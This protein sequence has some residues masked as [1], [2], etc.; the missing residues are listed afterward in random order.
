MEDDIN[1][2]GDEG[3]PTQ[4][5]PGV[6]GLHVNTANDSDELSDTESAHLETQSRLRRLSEVDLERKRKRGM[7]PRRSVGRG[8]WLLELAPS[9]QA[10]RS[11]QQCAVK[12]C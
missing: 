10:H 7:A 4:A 12:N 2:E 5:S 11:P 9:C 8:I 1:V 3:G 6:Q